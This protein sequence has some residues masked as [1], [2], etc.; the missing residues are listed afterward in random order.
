M[1]FLANFMHFIRDSKVSQ[2][3][4]RPARLCG[5]EHD[6][7]LWC[8]LVLVLVVVDEHGLRCFL[9]AVGGS[10]VDR[11]NDERDVDADGDVLDGRVIAIV[12]FL[13]ENFKVIFGI[14][15]IFYFFYQLNEECQPKE[16]RNHLD[17]NFYYFIT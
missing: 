6:I 12:A 5:I 14:L 15:N 7:L 9:L 13:L 1:I 17:R 8:L 10:V 3:S 11:E 4:L 16:H 2:F